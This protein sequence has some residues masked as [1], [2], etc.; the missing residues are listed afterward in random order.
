MLSVEL[1]KQPK[2]NNSLV[3]IVGAFRVKLRCSYLLA[4]WQKQSLLKKTGKWSSFTIDLLV[5]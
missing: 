4:I 2:D 5:S 1:Q 3:D